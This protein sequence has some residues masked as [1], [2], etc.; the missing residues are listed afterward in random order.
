MVKIVIGIPHCPAKDRI[1]DACGSSSLKGNFDVEFIITFQIRILNDVA[2]LLLMRLPVIFCQS[3]SRFHHMIFQGTGTGRNA[4]GL[5]QCLNNCFLMLYPHLPELYR[6]GILPFS[7]I[8]H[9]KDIA[10]PRLLTAHIQKGNSLRTTLYIA[11]HAVVP[12]IILR[13]SRCIRPLLKDHQLFRK[14]ILIK[15]C[16]CG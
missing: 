14:R 15:P 9:I 3:L 6:T 5:I 8:R 12:E 1:C 7:G 13:T 16:R 10:K 4:E 2:D 11:V